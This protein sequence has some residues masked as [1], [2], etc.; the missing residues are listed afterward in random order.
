MNSTGSVCCS[1]NFW[2][3]LIQKSPPPTPLVF[4]LSSPVLISVYRIYFSS[5]STQTS[6]PQCR[7]LTTARLFWPAFVLFF[8]NPSASHQWRG[9][10][11]SRIS[12]SDPRTSTHLRPAAATHTCAI[13][14]SVQRCSDNDFSGCLPA[15]CLLPLWSMTKRLISRGLFFFAAVQSTSGTL[16]D[17]TESLAMDTSFKSFKAAPGGSFIF[18]YYYDII[19]FSLCLLSDQ[20]EFSHGRGGGRRAVPAWL[21]PAQ[22]LPALLLAGQ[23]G[24]GGGFFSNITFRRLSL[25]FG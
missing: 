16:L 2:L 18:C 14:T 1:F 6:K 7:L 8:K 5:G 4:L 11:S 21:G 19:V 13:V 22:L 9:R 20:W 25:T 12:T 15:C 23:V 24:A 3:T 17:Q 10:G